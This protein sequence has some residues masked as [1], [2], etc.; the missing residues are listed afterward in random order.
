MKIEK[1]ILQVVFEQYKDLENRVKKFNN[2]NEVLTTPKETLEKFD[3]DAYMEGVEADSK[4]HEMIAKNYRSLK[5]VLFY[6]YVTLK[7]DFTNNTPLLEKTF[8]VYENKEATK[9]IKISIN[10]LSEQIENEEE[11]EN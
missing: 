9:G 7:V 8:L 10:E 3:T 4:I 5:Y 2:E 1:K 11:F 6:D